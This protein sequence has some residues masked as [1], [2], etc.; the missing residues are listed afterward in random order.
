[1]LVLLYSGYVNSLDWNGRLD[2]WPGVL[3]PVAHNFMQLC[4]FDPDATMLSYSYID[5]KVVLATL[6]TE[7][8]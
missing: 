6:R 2:H 8:T 1:M 7:L 4:M 5:C 3:E